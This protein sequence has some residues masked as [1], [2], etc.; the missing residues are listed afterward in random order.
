MD[1]I[2][3]FRMYNNQKSHWWYTTKRAYLHAILL[4]LVQ[5]KNNKILDVGCG[6]GA[7][8]PALKKFGSVS[9]VDQSPHAIR[10]AK[11]AGVQSARY[12]RAQELPYK[13]S[14]FD[15]VTILDVLYHKKIP[16][17]AVVLKEIYR[18]LKPNGFII[19][20]SCA[21]QFLYGPYDVA[22]HGKKRYSKKELEDLV[23]CSGFQTIKSSYL[24]MTMFPVFVVYRMLQKVNVFSDINSSHSSN[25]VLNAILSFV[26]KLE[27]NLLPLISFPFGSSL[28]II[29]Q[30]K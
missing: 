23:S 17:E 10:L 2:E 16:H 28:L 25:V 12:A 7:N 29:G 9:A 5:T 21:H 4:N 13:K 26:G 20:T 8:I 14:V 30:K 1:N 6:S 22:T 18:V 19:L 24:Y 3:Y 27:A 15:I 11:L